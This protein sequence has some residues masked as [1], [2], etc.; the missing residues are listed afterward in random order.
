[1]NV[2]RDE[3]EHRIFVFCF[4]IGLFISEKER[5]EELQNE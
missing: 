2:K 1:M 4:A 5:C 3:K